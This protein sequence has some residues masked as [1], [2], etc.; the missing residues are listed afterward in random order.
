MAS[1]M[2]VFKWIIL[3]Q[4]FYSVS[5]TTITYATPVDALDYVTGFSDLGDQID[6]N[7]VSSDIQESVNR[8]TSL[9]VVELGALVFYSGNI[10]LDLMMNFFFAIPEMFILLINGIASLFSIDVVLMGMI[11]I[12]LTV[13]IMVMWLISIIEMFMSFRSGTGRVT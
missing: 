7:R 13:V 12:F 11:Q 8:Q 4:V 3:V 1:A 9:P 2:D 10:V 6:I 5:I